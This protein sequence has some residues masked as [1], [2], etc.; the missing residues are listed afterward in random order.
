MQ[1][2]SPVKISQIL[3]R[4]QALEKKIQQFAHNLGYRS[5]D[6][7]KVLKTLLTLSNSIS[8]VFL[9]HGLHSLSSKIL[10]KSLSADVFLFFYGGKSEKR[11]SGRAILYCNL[12]FLLIK[13]GE[14]PSALNFLYDSESL[15]MEI[16][17]IQDCSDLKLASSIIGFIAMCRLGKI[18]SAHE[19]LETATEQYNLIIR[20]GIKTKYDE[21]SCNNLY[22][23]LT[24]VGEVLQNQKAI[25]DFQGFR[26]EIM[27]K[28]KNNS[29]SAATVLR[30]L[31]EAEEWENGIE[32]ICSDEWVNYLFL[33]VFF[34]FI[35]SNTPVIDVN[36]IIRA[37]ENET[38]GVSVLSP[39]RGG[40][41]KDIYANLMENALRAI[42]NTKAR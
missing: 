26:L 18:N 2:N 24:F 27:R 19:Y 6:T 12:A 37:K 39:T 36:E 23:S 21:E 16:T 35:T 11:W 7:T 17:A 5:S 20:E 15:L 31:L 40:S 14:I 8:I 4:V 25:N 29:C 10:K 28:I 13:T 41:K 38:G 34:P 9:Y 42:S 30:K 33:I 3:Q 32:V 22:F 1:E